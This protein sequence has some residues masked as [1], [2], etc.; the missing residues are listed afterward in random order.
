MAIT[1]GGADA[2]NATG[3]VQVDIVLRRGTN[4]PRQ[5][6]VLLRGQGG[7]RRSTS[8][9]DMAAALGDTTGKGIGPM[10]ITTTASIRRSLLKD[11]VW[12]WG[13]I[14][15][16]RINLLTLNGEADNTSFETSAFKAEGGCND[17]VRGTSLLR[18]QQDRD[19]RGAGPT[20]SPE[21]TWSQSGPAAY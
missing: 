3:G 17:A 1:T 12:V 8:L 6:A 15:R 11:S 16:S 5:P 10:H 7:S 19:G 4:L 14:G 9:P 21:T 20:R 2:R 13:A 18:Q